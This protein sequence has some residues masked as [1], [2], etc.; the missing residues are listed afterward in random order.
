MERLGQSSHSQLEKKLAETRASLEE[1]VK[2]VEAA[3]AAGIAAAE[4]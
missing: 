4:K 3:K 2:A 1:E